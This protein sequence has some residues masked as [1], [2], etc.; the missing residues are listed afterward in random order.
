M[1]TITL[2]KHF[3]YAGDNGSSFFTDW[4]HF[5]AEQMNAQL[6]VV[7]HS[8]VST[9]SMGVQLQTT[10]DTASAV[11]VGSSVT[12]GAPGTS[13]VDIT[14]GLGPMVRLQLSSSAEA[15]ITISVYLTPKSE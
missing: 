7:V 13:Q 2:L 12:T 6:V 5:P 9:G 4:V 10:W 11:S 14:S 3:S 1:G 8:R 15:L